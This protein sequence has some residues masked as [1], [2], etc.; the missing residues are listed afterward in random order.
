MYNICYVIR[1]FE[2][3]FDLLG[4]IRFKMHNIF[5]VTRSFRMHKMIIEKNIL[6]L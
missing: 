5:H 4:Y 2:M 6:Q 1:S 3:L